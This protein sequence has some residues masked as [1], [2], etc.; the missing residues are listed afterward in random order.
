M[1][2][3]KLIKLLFDK[4]ICFKYYVSSTLFTISNGTLLWI[5]FASSP[6]SSLLVGSTL[7]R[8]KAS[9]CL[10]CCVRMT[11]DMALSSLIALTMVT[12]SRSLRYR[13]SPSEYMVLFADDSSVVSQA[14][15]NES[16]ELVHARCLILPSIYKYFLDTCFLIIFAIC[17]LSG[18]LALFVNIW[19]KFNER[20]IIINFAVYS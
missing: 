19:S 14:S 13:S 18:F 3:I 15:W 12:Q 7:S 5:D 11:L 6:S 1:K 2:L 20:F 10:C 9:S 17:S 16:E 4:E 8:S